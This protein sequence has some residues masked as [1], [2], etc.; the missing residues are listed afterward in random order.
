[1]ES[2]GGLADGHTYIGNINLASETAYQIDLGL[3]YQNKSIMIAPH[4]F[5]QNIDDYIQGSSLT[6]VD[7]SAK[8]IAKMM[9]NDDAA[10]KFSNVDAKLYGMDVNGYY[11]FNEQFQLSTIISY[12][13]GQRR[14]IED[15]LYRIAPL[16]GRLI[17]SYFAEELITSFSLLAVSAQTNVSLTNNEQT[18][19]GYGV[20]NIDVQYFVNNS[21][22]VRAGIDNLLDREYQNHLGGYNR[23]KGSDIA[24][25][26][27]LPSEGMSAWLD[28]I[29][30]F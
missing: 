6:M 14:D 18:T 25:M 17:V 21:L 19:S 16:N 5:Y 2:T 8:M 26:S 23:I 4:V 22:S 30:S 10:L 20:V 9:S 15:N 24:V 27:R 3:T 12:V 29:Y 28:V 1:M 7:K 11:H 13:R